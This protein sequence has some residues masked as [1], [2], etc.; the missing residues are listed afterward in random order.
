MKRKVDIVTDIVTAP[1]DVIYNCK[2]DCMDNRISTN[3]DCDQEALFGQKIGPL[4]D[5]NDI[6]NS[7]VECVL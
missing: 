3:C 1:C 2:I 7:V 6:D 4:F 5:T